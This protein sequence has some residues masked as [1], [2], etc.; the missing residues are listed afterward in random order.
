MIICSDQDPGSFIDYIQ[1]I[2]VQLTYVLKHF[3]S[4]SGS[5]IFKTQVFVFTCFFPFAVLLS[6]DD[7]LFE[8]FIPKCFEPKNQKGVKPEGHKNIARS[9]SEHKNIYVFIQRHLYLALQMFL[10]FISHKCLSKDSKILG[11]RFMCFQTIVNRKVEHIIKY[12]LV[13]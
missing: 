1:F 5:L 9:F 2:S 4:I 8:N 11:Q 12:L 3:L 13:V 10:I 6:L 7:V